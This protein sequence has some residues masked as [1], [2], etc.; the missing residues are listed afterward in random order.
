[1]FL[2]FVTAPL[3]ALIVAEENAIFRALA[4][5]PFGVLLAAM[6]VQ[7]LWTGSVGRP[8]RSILLGPARLRW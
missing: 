7:A 3:A 5:L 8:L 2:G 6:G 4:L 1:V